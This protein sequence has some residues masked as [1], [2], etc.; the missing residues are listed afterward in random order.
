MER[1]YSGRRPQICAD[2]VASTNTFSSISA[3]WL[4]YTRDEVNRYRNAWRTI[5]SRGISSPR[6]LL[7]PLPLDGPSVAK[8]D[9][10]GCVR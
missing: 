8:A 1:A 7:L 4:V 10:Q 2:F 6:L 5:T 9:A 3:S